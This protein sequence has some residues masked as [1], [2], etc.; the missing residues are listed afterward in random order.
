MLEQR[1]E[2]GS[3]VERDVKLVSY[4]LF[5]AFNWV[6]RWHRSSVPDADHIADV[7]TTF[8]VE[9]IG[10]PRTRTKRTA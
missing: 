2:D 1:I 3:I 8:F 10:A 7:F 9:G 5:A 6:A 4:A